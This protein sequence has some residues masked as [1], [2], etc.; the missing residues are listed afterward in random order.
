MSRW[1]Q[2]SKKPEVPEDQAKVYVGMVVCC[3]VCDEQNDD[4][5]YLPEVKA[6]TFKCEACG[7]LNIF[8][9]FGLAF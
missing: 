7:R 9:D 4:T 6:L 8:E 2:N 3:K 5:Y 1:T